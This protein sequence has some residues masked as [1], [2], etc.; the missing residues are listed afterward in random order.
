MIPPGDDIDRLMAVMAS[1]FDPA[2][3]EAWTRRQVEDAVMIGSC[4]YRL[5]DSAAGEPDPDA[6]AA[7]FFLSPLFLTIAST[8]ALLVV[9][10]WEAISIGAKPTV[11]NKALEIARVIATKSLPALKANKICNNAV[12]GLTWE[13]GYK[14]TQEYSANLT[15]GMDAKEGIRAF[16][17]R[18]RANYSD[19]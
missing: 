18:R 3:G 4:H 17:E 5:I 10:A 1:A 6:P 13:E 9:A 8:L 11:M 7:G 14:L 19:R 15:A 2:Y 16:L 12:E